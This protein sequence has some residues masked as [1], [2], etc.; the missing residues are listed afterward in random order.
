[1]EVYYRSVGHGAVLLLNGASDQSGMIPACDVA[2]TAKFG[3]EIRRRFGK[4]IVETHGCGNV[5]IMTFDTTTAVDHV[6]TME[7][8]SQGERVREYVLE[9][10][11]DGRWIEIT[12]G[13]AIGHKKI[14]LFP[15]TEVTK[16]RINVSRSVGDPIISSFAA[17]RVGTVPRIDRENVQVWDGLSAGSWEDLPL[18]KS[19]TLEFKISRHCKEAAQYGVEIIPAKSRPGPLHIEVASVTLVHDGVATSGFVTT[20]TEPLHYLLNITGF[21]Q[22]LSLRL[23][24]CKTSNV[25]APGRLVIHRLE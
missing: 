17:Y 4:P 6:I 23:E 2:R 20:G 3:A 8:I 5:V 22:K 13:T 21:D 24:M 18:D 19:R 7:D 1:M 11:R 14:D 9:G 25:A 12:R 15:P 10:E 16:I